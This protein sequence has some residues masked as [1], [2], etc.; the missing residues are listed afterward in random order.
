MKGGGSALLL[1]IEE[2]RMGLGEYALLK[3]NV[4]DYYLPHTLPGTRKG[5]YT[6]HQHP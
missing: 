1:S 4:L 2:E 5:K 3:A 6:C